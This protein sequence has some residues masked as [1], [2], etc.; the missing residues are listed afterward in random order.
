MTVSGTLRNVARSAGVLRL[1]LFGYTAITLLFIPAPGT[2]PVEHG[3]RIFPTLL[4]PISIPVLW[5]TLILDAVMSRLMMLEHPAGAP[6]R[7]RLRRLAWVDLVLALLI[8][9]FW[10]RYFRAIR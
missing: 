8:I 9:L 3:W 10:F 1:L 7:T 2:T 6:D 5:I 4:L